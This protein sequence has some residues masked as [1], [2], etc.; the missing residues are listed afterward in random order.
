QRPK[1]AHELDRAK[2]SS[3]LFHRGSPARRY[4][5]PRR[6]ADVERRFDPGPRARG[7]T[8]FPAREPSLRRYVTT[9]LGIRSMPRK[10][11]AAD[12]ESETAFGG[13]PWK[14][15]RRKPQFAH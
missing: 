10:R 5:R 1:D 15:Q 11:A 8:S 3:R 9:H 7:M 14:A 12:S 13:T 6:S 2:A 4:R